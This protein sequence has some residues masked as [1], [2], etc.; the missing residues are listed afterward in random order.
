MSYGQVSRREIR[1]RNGLTRKIVN[2][3][4]P[5]EQQTHMFKAMLQARLSETMRLMIVVLILILN[6]VSIEVITN[7]PIVTC[8]IVAAI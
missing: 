4:I 7:H 6:Y 3:T 5:V 8:E 1:H 2:H